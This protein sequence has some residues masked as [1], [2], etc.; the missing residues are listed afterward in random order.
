M[1]TFGGGMN[2]CSC[3]DGRNESLVFRLQKIKGR[4]KKLGGTSGGWEGEG[5][6]LRKLGETDKLRNVQPVQPQTNS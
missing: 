2:H 4:K 6:S 5:A 3:A 1:E